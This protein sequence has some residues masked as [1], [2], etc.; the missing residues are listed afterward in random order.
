MSHQHAS[1]CPTP[2]G[3]APLE[4]VYHPDGTACTCVP[5]TAGWLKWHTPPPPAGLA[6]ALAIA[7]EA[8][9]NAPDEAPEASGKDDAGGRG[10]H[11]GP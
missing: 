8:F 10:V 2:S 6:E 7:A 11:H 3:E 5:G 9:A 1:D 4:A